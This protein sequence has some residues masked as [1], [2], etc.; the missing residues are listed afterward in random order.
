MSLIAAAALLLGVQAGAANSPTLLP[1]GG[2]AIPE[3]IAP[4]VLRHAACLTEQVEDRGQRSNQSQITISDPVQYRR[5]VETAIRRCR[6][7]RLQAVAEADRILARAAEYRD[8]QRR[9]GAIEAAFDGVE[10]QQREMLGII[11]MLIQQGPGR[12]PGTN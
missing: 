3:P 2:V 9:E 10:Q 11:E 1:G 6:D 4:L 12:R 5:R 8:P 7:G